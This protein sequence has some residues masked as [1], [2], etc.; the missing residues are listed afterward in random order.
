MEAVKFGLIP[1]FI[2]RLH[3][4]FEEL[5]ESSLVKILTEPKNAITKQYKKLFEYDGITIELM[6]TLFRSGT[7]GLRKRPVPVVFAPS[8]SKL[9][10][11]LCTNFLQT[12]K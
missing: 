3:L 1:E 8:L 10:L 7:T 6:R 9:C 11:S 2:G 12:I 5:D 4:S